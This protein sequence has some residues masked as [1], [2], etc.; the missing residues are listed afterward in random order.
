MVIV[1]EH[2][3]GWVIRTTSKSFAVYAASAVEKN[4][5]IAHIERCVKDLLEKSGKKPSDHHAALWV[6]D[7][8]ADSC[9]RCRKTQFTIITRR[10]SIFILFLLESD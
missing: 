10:V 2:Q 6:P 3:N 1:S 4:E 5:W 8:E 7:T 9:M